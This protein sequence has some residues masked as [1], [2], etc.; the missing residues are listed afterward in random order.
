MAEAPP[1]PLQ[2]LAIPICPFFYFKT[3]RS[4]TMILA[5]LHPRGCPKATSS[6]RFKKYIKN[7]FF[8]KFLNK[9]IKRCKNETRY[10]PS[11]TIH[12]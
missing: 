7:K 6:Q 4:V 1:P 11:K 3:L 5:P 10:C 8:V 2:I 9:K 12:P